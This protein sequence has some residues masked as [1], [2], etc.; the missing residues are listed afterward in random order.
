[1]ATTLAIYG[2]AEQRYSAATRVSSISCIEWD[3]MNTG[4]RDTGQICA[5]L[6]AKQ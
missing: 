5:G 1:M 2:M 6:R 3:W 4:A